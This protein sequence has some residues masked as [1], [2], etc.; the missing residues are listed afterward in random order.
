ML[1]YQGRLCVPNV[2]GLRSLILKE[3][4]NSPY[5]IHLVST[6]LAFNPFEDKCSQGAILQRPVGR[7]VEIWQKLLN[8]I[9][10]AVCTT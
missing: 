9:P 6:K 8:T 10:G 7:K 2:D 5:S 1:S 4:H 3:T